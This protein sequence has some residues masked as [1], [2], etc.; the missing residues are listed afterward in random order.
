[1]S[2]LLDRIDLRFDFVAGKLAEHTIT[3]D[4]C[5]EYNGYI[6]KCGY[7]TFMI[8]SPMHAPKKR[9]YRAHRVSYAFHKG[10]DPGESLVCHR[11][12]NP[13]CINPGH[14]FLGSDMDNAQD[15]V[16]KGRSAPQDGETNPRSKVTRNIV[17]QIVADIQ[18]GMT[19]TDISVRYPV[20]HGQIS[21]IRL[22]KSWRRVTE[23]VGY[24]PAQHRKFERVGAGS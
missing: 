1:M 8:Y 24:D 5:W 3:D 4:G 11:C 20:S 18:S 22:G 7:G 13:R 10:V 16:S 19:N 6:N 21:L 23:E 17:L 2:E 14:L 9:K 15:R 12:D